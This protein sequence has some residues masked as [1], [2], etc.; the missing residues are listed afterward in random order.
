MSWRAWA[1]WSAPKLHTYTSSVTLAFP[2]R[3]DAAWLS[4]SSTVAVTPPARVAWPENCA[5]G[6]L[7]G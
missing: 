1:L 3:V 7:Q 2:G 6:G 5:T 4:A